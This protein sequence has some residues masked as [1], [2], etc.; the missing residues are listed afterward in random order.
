MTHHA[1]ATATSS[2]YDRAFA[3]SAGVL[4]AGALV[5]LLLPAPLGAAQ[6]SAPI[7]EGSGRAR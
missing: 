1:V 6:A 4:V 7:D 3:I 2:G 5:G